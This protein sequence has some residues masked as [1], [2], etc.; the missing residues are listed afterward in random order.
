MEMEKFEGEI[1]IATIY[2]KFSVY[3]ILSDKGEFFRVSDKE[4]KKIPCRKK[5]PRTPINPDGYDLVAI[6]DGQRISFEAAKQIKGKHRWAKN[7]KLLGLGRLYS[8]S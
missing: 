2:K 4:L 8:D 3:Y 5:A 7:I 6:E 1:Y